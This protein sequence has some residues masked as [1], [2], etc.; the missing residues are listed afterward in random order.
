[1]DVIWS[2]A[3]GIENDIQDN[4]HSQY[5]EK[6]E[7]HVNNLANFFFVNILESIKIV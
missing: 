6:A 4:P 1:M 3:F 7:Q 2:C 5:F